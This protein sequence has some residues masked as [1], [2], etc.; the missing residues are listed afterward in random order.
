MKILDFRITRFQFPRDRVIGDSQVRADE[1]HVATLELIGER[2]ETGLGFMQSLFH[3]LPAEDEIERTFREE[4]WPSIEGQQVE[5]LAHAVRRPRG[6]NVRRLGLPFEEALQH[7]TWDLFAKS[8]RMPLWKLLGAQRREVAAYA[9]GLDF[10]LSDEEFEKLFAQAAGQGFRA[11]KIK[12]GHPDV[13]RDLHRLALLKR[14]IG[15]DSKVMVDANEAWSA[16]QAIRNLMLM[17]R[18][19]HDIFWVEDPVLRDDF[20]G[21]KIIQDQCGPTLVNAGEYLDVSGKR[22]LLEARVCELLNVHGQVTD[23][24]RIGWLAADMGARITMGNT[25]LEVGVNMA[26][27]LPGVEWLEYSFQNF[28]HLVEQP[29]EIRDGRIFGSEAPGHG[30]VVSE[31]ARRTWHRPDVLSRGDQTHVPPQLRLRPS[32]A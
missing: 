8:L 29:Y 7:A 11:F 22:K 24:M 27:A 31:L 6:G 25:F 13:E 23:V 2:D 9:S 12:V 17:Q 32:G 5:A 14:I 18:A 4:C 19:G 10:H 21:L 26:L 28:E 30:L 20:A 3:P 1:V 15:P 16:K